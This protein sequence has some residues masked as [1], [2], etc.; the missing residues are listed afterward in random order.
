VKSL[1]QEWF[2]NEWANGAASRMEYHDEGKSRRTFGV[3]GEANSGDLTGSFYRHGSESVDIYKTGEIRDI[4]ELKRVVSHEIAHHWDWGSN[5]RLPLQ[6]RV[7]MLAGLLRRFADPKHFH[8]VYVEVDV[9]KEYKETLST[10]QVFIQQSKE[11]WA[12]LNERYDTEQE[13]L[14]EHQ[15]KDY[16]FVKHWRERLSQ[17]VQKEKR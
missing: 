10:E 2:G 5:R 13:A 1:I 3:A 15:P 4:N 14:R 7:S 9:P 6:E 8:S 17:P 12:T 11:F 16:E